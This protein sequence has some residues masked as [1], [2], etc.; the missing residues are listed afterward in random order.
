MRTVAIIAAI[1]G[2]TAA[3]QAAD[4]ILEQTAEM[5]DGAATV[6]VPALIKA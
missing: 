2:I 4:I 3:A 5:Y 6:I 1:I